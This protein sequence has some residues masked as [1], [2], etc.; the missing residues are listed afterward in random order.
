[1][2][3][4]IQFTKEEVKSLIKSKK[5]CSIDYGAK[6]I[7]IATTDFMH[8]SLNPLMT[9]E[10]EGTETLS[11][12]IELIRKNSIEAI[13][14]GFPVRKGELESPIQMEILKFKEN[15]E[16][17]ID[18]PVILHDESGSSIAASSNMIS[19]GVKKSDRREKGNL[20]RFAALNILKNFLEEYEGI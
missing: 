10:N 15:L 4:K 13:V 17:E 8:I 20:D 9:L 1:M 16:E 3:E 11:K 12:I 6:R 18:L 5:I 14:L 19:S 2:S 7:G